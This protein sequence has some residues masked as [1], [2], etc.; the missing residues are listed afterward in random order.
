MATAELQ[1]IVPLLSLLLEVLPVV[2]V[3][4]Y[5]LSITWRES[6]KPRLIPRRTIERE[7]D[8]LIATFPDPLREVTAR[9]ERTWHF[10]E[11]WKAVYWSRVRKVVRRRVQ[12]LPQTVGSE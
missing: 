12:R 6:I 9:C 2:M 1:G 5:V 3:W 7:A 8:A 11:R 10:R 4:G